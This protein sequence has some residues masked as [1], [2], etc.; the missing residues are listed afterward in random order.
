MDQLPQLALLTPPSVA[1]PQLPTVLTGLL[2]VKLPQSKTKDNAVHAGHSL[3]LVVLIPDL[4]LP[5]TTPQLSTQSNN[6]L[7]ALDHMEIMVAMVV[8]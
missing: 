7:I 3:L 1:L 5:K 6:L 8:S 4:L 2:K